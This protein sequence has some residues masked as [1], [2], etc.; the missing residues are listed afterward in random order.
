[1]KYDGSKRA[2]AGIK[3]EENEMTITE[4]PKSAHKIPF[5][6]FCTEIF[7]VK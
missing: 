2:L 7:P 1:M 4:P 5:L 3:C 6:R